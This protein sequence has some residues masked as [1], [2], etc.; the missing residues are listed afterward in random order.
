MIS[1]ALSFWS[2]RIVPRGRL[3]FDGMAEGHSLS[4]PP[5]KMVPTAVATPANPLPAPW[6][7]E[8]TWKEQQAYQMANNVP[9]EKM[10]PTTKMSHRN[11]SQTTLDTSTMLLRTH[12]PSRPSEWYSF[13]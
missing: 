1:S 10:T 3:G 13:A 7:K 9:I 5:F 11:P 4:S 2:Y 12:P 8:N 6:K